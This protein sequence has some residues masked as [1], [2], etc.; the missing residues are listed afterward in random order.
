MERSQAAAQC[1][2]EGS[3]VRCVSVCVCVF[4]WVRLCDVCCGW[5]SEQDLVTINNYMCGLDADIRRALHGEPSKVM[6]RTTEVL[7][8]TTAFLLQGA[9]ALW[10]EVLRWVIMTL[11]LD[12]SRAA[13]PPLPSTFL[14][15][16]LRNFNDMLQPDSLAHRV[17]DFCALW[18]D[19]LQGPLLTLLRMEPVCQEDLAGLAGLGMW[20]HLCQFQQEAVGIATHDYAPSASV[21][22]AQAAKQRHALSSSAGMAA[23]AEAEHATVATKEADAQGGS[24]ATVAAEQGDALGASAAMVA[25]KQSD[26][27]GGSVAVVATK[28][29]DA[30]GGSTAMVATKHHD[31]LGGAVATAAAKQGNALGG[32][33]AT[34][35]AKQSDALGGSVAVVAT[36]QSDA[37][38]GST[39]MV[40]ATES[41]ALGASAAMAATTQGNALGDSGATVATKQSDALGGSIAVVA[42]KQSDALGGSTAAVPPEAAKQSLEQERL[43]LLAL[44]LGKAQAST[45]GDVPPRQ[46][47]ELSTVLQ[48]IITWQTTNVKP[49]VDAA[50]V[51]ANKGLDEGFKDCMS[52]IEA[53]FTLPDSDDKRKDTVSVGGERLQPTPQPPPFDAT[54]AQAPAPGEQVQQWQRAHQLRAAAERSSGSGTSTSTAGTKMG[55]ARW[56]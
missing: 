30:L 52:D 28:Q 10:L 15:P 38:G 25:A 11:P 55:R 32:S 27:L 48:E 24:A 19:M 26:A 39:A 14:R 2:S 20:T 1:T 18:L 12:A 9:V 17:V 5:T 41:G 16:H 29:S 43:E 56:Q 44:Q 34:R 8:K 3:L 49:F 22:A 46:F 37:L 53:L 33:P 51:E 42:T 35:A 50:T 4:V 31:A 47:K 13:K 21:A 40:A 54:A 6:Q 23:V 36:K 7:Q 45:I